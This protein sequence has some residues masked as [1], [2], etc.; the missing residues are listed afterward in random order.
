MRAVKQQLWNWAAKI[1][2]NTDHA[3]RTRSWIIEQILIPTVLDEC[4]Q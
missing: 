3:D 2:N 1:R 4:A